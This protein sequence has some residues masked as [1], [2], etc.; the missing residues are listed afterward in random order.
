M[1]EVGE[2]VEVRL[3]TPQVTKFYSFPKE[4]V[5]LLPCNNTSSE[6]LASL[7]LESLLR[8]VEEEGSIKVQRITVTIIESAGQ[9]V[10]VTQCL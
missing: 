6:N 9:K 4:D 1:Q 3:R 10:S 5:V 8:R 7:F 2:Q